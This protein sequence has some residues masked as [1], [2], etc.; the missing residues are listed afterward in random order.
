MILG[1]E[2]GVLYYALPLQKV[3]VD[4]LVIDTH[5]LILDCALIYCCFLF[6]FKNWQPPVTTSPMTKFWG[7][8]AVD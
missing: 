3:G 5:I 6:Y 2:F 7:L 1:T 8:G 4:D